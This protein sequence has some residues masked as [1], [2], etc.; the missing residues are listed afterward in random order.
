MIRLIIMLVV[1]G[2]VFATVGIELG[3]IWIVWTMKDK[4]LKMLKSLWRRVR[5][6]RIATR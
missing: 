4:M 1:S 2:T 6:R 5:L 3:C